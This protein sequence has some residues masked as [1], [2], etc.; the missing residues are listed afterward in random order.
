[1]VIAGGPATLLGPIVGAALVV[2][3]K[4]VVSRLHRAL[5]FP[6]RRDLRRHRHPD[7][8]GPG[9]R[10]GAAVARRAGARSAAGAARSRER[11]ADSAERE[12]HERAHRQRALQGV[13]RPARHHRRQPQ[14]RAGRAAADHRPERRRQDHAVQPDH[15][16]ADAGLR[17]DP[18][19]RP[20]HHRACRAAA[21]R[22]SA[23]RAPTRSS[24]CSPATPSCATSRWR[25]SAC[26]RALEPAHRARP[27]D[28][29]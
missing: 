11:G 21:A 10:H 18:P 20:G 16:R 1:M 5:E 27:A 7:A 22:I 23:W 26:R 24:R 25:C 2:I 28:A 3:V 4:N 6:A 15:R 8:G 14:C 19:V 12:S 29:T 13:R 17:L 9:A